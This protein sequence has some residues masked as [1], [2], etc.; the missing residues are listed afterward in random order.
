MLDEKDLPDFSDLQTQHLGRSDRL[1][2]I[3]KF[4]FNAETDADYQCFPHFIT[5]NK[6][7]FERNHNLIP[8]IEEEDYELLLQKTRDDEDPMVLTLEDVKK[9]PE[10]TL[11][12][13]TACAGNKR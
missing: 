7:Q 3:A 4:P 2:V 9:M 11:V 12:A 5:P 6:L 1:K 10:Y 13:Y 8:E